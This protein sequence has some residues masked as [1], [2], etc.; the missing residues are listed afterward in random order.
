MK[1]AILIAL[2]LPVTTALGANTT[3]ERRLIQ[4]ATQSALLNSGTDTF[5]FP[6]VAENQELPSEQP[7]ACDT[8]CY[9]GAYCTDSGGYGYCD[10]GVWRF[11]TCR[12]TL[13]CDGCAVG[14]EGS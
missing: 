3:S 2:L 14:C 13:Y 12:S 10:G 11:F 5:E 6:R 4:Q 8:T 9:Y 1:F 7:L